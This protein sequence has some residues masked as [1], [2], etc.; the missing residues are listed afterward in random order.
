MKQRFFALSLALALQWD[1]MLT[2][3]ICE[4]G[5]L[6]YT[7]QNNNILWATL[8]VYFDLMYT[9][10]ATGRPLAGM[11]LTELHCVTPGM[12][13]HLLNSGRGWRIQ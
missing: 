2:I 7:C 3:F 10:W 1:I 12:L 13:L 4:S 6:H 5:D 11:S 9:E 8:E